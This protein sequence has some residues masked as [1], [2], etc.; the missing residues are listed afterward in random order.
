MRRFLLSVAVLAALPYFAHA[1]VEHH[2]FGVIDEPLDHAPRPGSYRPV[3]SFQEM[4]Q[5]LHPNGPEPTPI[6]T[7]TPTPNTGG[8]GM[9]GGIATPVP[10]AE[11]ENIPES[12][13]LDTED[14][15]AAQGGIGKVG[16]AGIDKAPALSPEAISEQPDSTPQATPPTAPTGSGIGNIGGGIG[17]VGGSR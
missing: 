17:A 15:D 10:T 2:I 13:D 1:Q 14:N 4:W 5:Y 9:V 3:R 7:P 11:P 8:I 12:D 16:G 6:V